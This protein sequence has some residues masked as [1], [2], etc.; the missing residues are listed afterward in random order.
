MKL[1]KL[2]LAQSVLVKPGKNGVEFWHPTAE[3]FPNEAKQTSITPGQPAHK[4]P[5]AIEDLKPKT[6]KTTAE[7][8]LKDI[9]HRV[10]DY[11]NSAQHDLD[12]SLEIILK[13]FDVSIGGA[14]ARSVPLV[15]EL[16]EARKSVVVL[17]SQLPKL[18]VDLKDA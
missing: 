1:S 4:E 9:E 10:G 5:L 15:K 2:K 13:E 3:L 12:K 6:E 14:S 11:L 8:N 16:L 18:L 17:K 7:L